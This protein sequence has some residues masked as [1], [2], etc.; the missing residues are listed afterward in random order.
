MS[1][2]GCT[3]VDL[4]THLLKGIQVVSSFAVTGN[5]AMNIQVRIFVWN[6]EFVSL[7]LATRSRMTH[8]MVAVYFTC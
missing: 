4:N 6:Y 1:W 8:E 3:T 7:E 2:Y 5:T